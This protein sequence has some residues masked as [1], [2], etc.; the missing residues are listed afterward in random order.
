MNTYPARKIA[1]INFTGFR[2]NWGCQA[3]SW[4][5]LS[6]LN[7]NLETE[8]LPKISPIPLLPRHEMDLRLEQQELQDIYTAMLDVCQS[9]SAAGGALAYLEELAL[10]RYGQYASQA[11]MADLVFFQAEGT[12]AGTDFL[13]GARLLLLPFVAKHAWKKPVLSLNQTIFSCNDG[14]TPVMAAAYNSFDLVAVRENISFD[15]AQ[16]AGIREVIHIPD[17]AFLVRPRRAAQDIPAGRHFA[18]TGTAWFDNRPES[19]AHEKIFAAADRIRQ[20]SG[21]IPLVAVSTGPDKTLI[22][23]ARKHWGEDG[24]ASIPPNSSHT[25]AAY[26]LQQCRL[27][28]GGRYHMTIMA[29]AAGTPAIQLPGNSYKNEGLS[30]MLGE[31]CPV[32]A[33]DD[34][35]AITEDAS[36]ILD[37]PEGSAAR[38][39]NALEPVRERLHHAKRYFASLQKGHPAPVPRCLR[40]APGQTVSAAD[41]I[42]S[43]RANTVRQVGHFRY[44]AAAEDI[45]GK[46]PSPHALFAELTSAY[47]DGDHLVR[48]NL[49]QILGS[50]SNRIN[51]A[52]PALKNAIY[53]LPPELFA[54]AGIPRPADPEN[55]ITGLED[56]RRICGD[57]AIDMRE[58]IIPGSAPALPRPPAKDISFHFATLREE[59]ATKPELLFYHA[60]LISLI[61]RRLEKDR[62]FAQFRAIWTEE[63]EFLRREL[64]SRWLVSAC[65]TFADHAE[66]P[67]ERALAMTG[68]I[69]TDT[70][71]LYETENWAT[72]QNGTARQYRAVPPQIPLFDGMT[73]FGI[74]RGDLIRNMQRRLA[75]VAN[76]KSVVSVIVFELFHRIHA[77]DTVFRRFHSMH[78]T[79]G[80]HWTGIVA[81][82]AAGG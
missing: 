43:Y 31:I 21:L 26:A 77:H 29:L 39:Q 14:F 7:G 3:T 6:L 78:G 11:K 73:A 60:A 30:A 71:K 40:S 75:T 19:E 70:V 58:R 51:A 42:E 22:E 2:P 27:V 5:L 65:N 80:T 17:A 44:S 47:R 76:K 23:L 49:I 12:M 24:F 1:I 63:T 82:P 59:F 68:A 72:G 34:Q 28:L 69:L 32:R 57:R 45:L 41:H 16:K 13:R 74:G 37:D 53:R 18:V 67:A 66:D 56:L 61:R 8:A 50:F 48:R 38:L 36:R 15:A 55:P 9:G 4:G 54:S 52:R 20:E 10:R 33:F 62:A 79:P 35:E 81:A 46:E 25:A 64:D